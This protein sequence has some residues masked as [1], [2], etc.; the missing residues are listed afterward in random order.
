MRNLVFVDT[1]TQGLDPENDKLIELSWAVN[2]GPIKT[3]YFGV[4]EVSEFIDNLIGFT[5][6]GIAGK[7]SPLDDIDEFV[8]DSRGQTVVAANRYF[9]QRFLEVNGLWEA[10][11][12]AIEMSSYAMGRLGLDY[13]PGM[14]DIEREI[15]A[16][17]FKIPVAADHTSANDV[18]AMRYMFNVLKFL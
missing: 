3:I 6:R 2:D 14:K 12:R 9:D 13:I 1:E 4:E 5:K 11:Y 15:E 18:N 7:Q 10:H 17:G 8:D 16:L